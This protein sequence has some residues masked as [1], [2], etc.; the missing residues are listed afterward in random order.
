MQARNL[1]LEAGITANLSDLE[2][3]VNQ[4]KPQLLESIRISPD[5]SPSYRLLLVAA[6]S[7]YRES[8][9]GAF[10]LLTEMHQ[11]SPVQREALDMR[12]KLFGR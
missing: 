1:F 6:Q 8:P 3:F 10:E 11:S 5:F 4:A 9:Q 12:K 2:Q 7:L